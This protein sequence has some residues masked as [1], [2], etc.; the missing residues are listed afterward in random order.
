MNKKC[1]LI[2]FLYTFI[3]IYGL[4]GD[5]SDE[6]LDN[7][8]IFYSRSNIIVREIIYDYI[9]RD[10]ITSV[11]LYGGM[12]SMTLAIYFNAGVYGLNENI[13][14]IIEFELL[15][16]LKETISIDNFSI[17]TLYPY[18]IIF[19]NGNNYNI[20]ER[21][22]IKNEISNNGV[23]VY[24][25][26]QNI[27][28]GYFYDKYFGY[29]SEWSNERIFNSFNQFIEKTNEYFGVGNILIYH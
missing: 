14:N 25:I 13:N 21:Q 12:S 11:D 8:I 26:F 19:N 3:V 29:L 9:N 15:E 7:L 23:L 24:Q 18:N 28:Y 22:R 20:Y 5:E 17:V 10:Y 4:F 2:L 16:K 1:N 6:Y 27:M